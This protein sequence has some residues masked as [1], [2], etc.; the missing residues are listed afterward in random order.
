MVNSGLLEATENDVASI[1]K[2][3]HKTCHEPVNTRRKLRE[4]QL[5]LIRKFTTRAQFTAPVAGAQLDDPLSFGPE[6]FYCWDIRKVVVS[7]FTAGNV[8]MYQFPVSDDNQEWTFT[9]NTQVQLYGSAG[10]GLEEGERLIF[11]PQ[12]GITGNITVGIRG[13]QVP[14]LLWAEY[15]L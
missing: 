11:V 13:Y 9:T 4:D 7:T 2:S 5:Q 15:L 3:C 14:R 1:L 8:I 12:A 10:L 6:S